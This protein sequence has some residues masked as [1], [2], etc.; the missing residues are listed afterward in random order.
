MRLDRWF[1][2]VGRDEAG[3]C[4]EVDFFFLRFGDDDVS[5]GGVSS[6]FTSKF[7]LRIQYFFLVRAAI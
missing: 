5:V 1:T 7:E 4:G 3:E 2:N 6:S